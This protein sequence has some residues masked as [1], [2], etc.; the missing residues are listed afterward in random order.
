MVL[1][2]VLYWPN[3]YLKDDVSPL[4]FKIGGDAEKI[5]LGTNAPRSPVPP[6]PGTSI[7]PWEH[8]TL[9]KLHL[10]VFNN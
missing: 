4:N 9:H 10:Y 6:I 2:V 5:F 8:M 3:F 7:R 1:Y